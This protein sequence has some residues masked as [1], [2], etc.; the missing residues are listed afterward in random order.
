MNYQ[1]EIDDLFVS[2]LPRAFKKQVIVVHKALLRIF[3]R[4]RGVLLLSLTGV[5]RQHCRVVRE[6]DDCGVVDGSW[7]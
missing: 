4:T 5:S 1:K 6:V 2:V 3:T 7:L